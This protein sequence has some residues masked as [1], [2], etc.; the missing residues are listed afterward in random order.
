M[1]ASY[2]H[3]GFDCPHTTARTAHTAHMHEGT[4]RAQ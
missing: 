2:S 4:L 1:P 3:K